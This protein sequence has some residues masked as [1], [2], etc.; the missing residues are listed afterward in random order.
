MNDMD[1]L[2][3][4][5]TEKEFEYCNETLFQEP[6][7]C[8]GR[9]KMLSPE[10]EFV[11][12]L[13]SVVDKNVNMIN[14]YMI[15]TLRRNLSWIFLPHPAHSWGPATF[16][17][18]SFTAMIIIYWSPCCP[19]WSYTDR[20]ACLFWLTTIVTLLLPP[21]ASTP[22]SSGSR[23][24]SCSKTC[25]ACLTLITKIVRLWHIRSRRSGPCWAAFRLLLSFWRFLLFQ[26]Q[27][28][29][30]LCSLPCFYINSNLVWCL[31]SS[32]VG[33]T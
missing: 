31:F 21:Q 17:L 10:C 2:V 26:D 18:S 1:L 13:F 20:S 22:P 12:D 23:A 28:M 3:G 4:W 6:T 30:C 9:Y 11:V 8:D 33:K 24:P 7:S 32:S 15:I 27:F 29:V 25:S 14:I 16:P 5:L 19:L